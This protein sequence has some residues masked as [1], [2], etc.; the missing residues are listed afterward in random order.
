LNFDSNFE[1]SFSEISEQVLGVG[2][3]KMEDKEIT[4]KNFMNFITL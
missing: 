1:F 4:K 2:G 3:W